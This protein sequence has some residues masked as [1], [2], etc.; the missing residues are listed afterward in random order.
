[1]HRYVRKP[2]I[3]TDDL[4]RNPAVRAFVVVR[5]RLLFH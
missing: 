1:V 4:E 5:L 2:Y 3:H